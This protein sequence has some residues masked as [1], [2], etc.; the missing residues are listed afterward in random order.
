MIDLKTKEGKALSKQEA[1]QLIKEYLDEQV[2]LSRRKMVDEEI[3]NVPAHSEYI[4]FQLGL[5]KAFLK[6]AFRQKICLNLLPQI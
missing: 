5:Q 4:A 3:F 6:L 1:F 2:E